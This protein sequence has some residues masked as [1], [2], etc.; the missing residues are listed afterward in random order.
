M[1]DL[2]SHLRQ[3]FLLDELAAALSL[4]RETHLVVRAVLFWRV[5]LAAASLLAAHVVLR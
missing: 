1:L 5:S 3:I 2:F 4:A